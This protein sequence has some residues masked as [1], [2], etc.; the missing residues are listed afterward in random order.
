MGGNVLARNTAL[1]LGGRTISLLV[2]VFAMPYVIRHLG[3][4]RFGLLSLAWIV[5]GYFA[6]LD[7]GIGTATTKFVAEFLGKGNPDAVPKVVWTAVITQLCLGTVGG[8]LLA[9]TSPLLADRVFKIPV[10]LHSEAR[11]VFLILAFSL[12]IDLANGSLQ[13]VLAAT[14]RFDLVNAI[15]IPSSA[16]TYLIPVAALALGCGLPAIVLFLVAARLVAVAVSFVVCA[17][18]YPSLTARVRFDRRLVRQLVGFGGWVTVSGA[19]NPILVYFD[20]FLIGALIS[21]AGIGYYTPPYM[22]S[23]KLSIIPASL[24]ATLFPAFSASAGRGDTEWIRS[25]LVRSLK[26]L[27]LVVGLIAVLLFFFAHPILQLWLGTRY[28]AEGT[29]VLQILTAGVLM[30]SL[31]NVPGFLLL[32][33]GRPDICAKFHL[34]ELPFHM[35]LAWF[36]VVHFGLAGAAL[37]W[38]IR[39]SVDFLLLIIAASRV[40]HTSYRLFLGRDFRRSVVTLGAL[41][42]SLALVWGT[43]PT[44]VDRACCSAIIGAAVA[45]G[46]WQYILSAEEKWQFKTL[47]RIRG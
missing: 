3:P 26:F 42:V 13:G 2:A 7:L 41:A 29:I 46:A 30:N 47:L 28:A 32:A 15:G 10:E 44:L 37:A 4:D 18:L 19:V 20:R 9:A 33:M 27:L 23:T 17:R 14:Q 38:T 22:I 6:L 40:T 16:L 43:V 39:V 8:I 35:I 21:I 31:A 1:N 34:L 45:L 12:P 11:L 36:L 24:I 5:V 25:A